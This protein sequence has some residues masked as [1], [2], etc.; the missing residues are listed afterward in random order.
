MRVVHVANRSDNYAYVD[1]AYAM[2]NAI[3]QAPPDYGFDYQ[4]THPWVW[5]SSDRSARLVEPVEGGYR[6]YY[7]QPGANEPYLVRDPQY[8][9]GYSDGQLASVYDSRGQLLPDEYI[10]RR[11]D[12]AGRYLVRGASL[13]EASLRNEKRSVNA[14]NWSGRR[15]E[16]DSARAQWEEQQNREEAWRAY[17]AEHDAEGQS[18]WQAERERRDR[19]A[20]SFDDWSRRSYAGPPPAV[21]YGN[22]GNQPGFGSTM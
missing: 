18:Y 8:S 7:Y 13:Y 5:R 6:Y 1:R 10:D 12:D 17:H 16:L 4:G 2:S 19:S 11:T 14:E 3:G 20:R 21:Y 9:Y 22:A 15:A